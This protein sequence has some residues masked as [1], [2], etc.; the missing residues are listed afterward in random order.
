MRQERATAAQEARKKQ[1]QYKE[2]RETKGISKSIEYDNSAAYCGTT[3]RSAVDLPLPVARHGVAAS[4]ATVAATVS[5]RTT[6]SQSSAT[7][8]ATATRTSAS[9]ATLLLDHK[10]T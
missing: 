8:A 4:R 1:K 10:H 3:G 2:I 7:V 6:A 5:R 9:I